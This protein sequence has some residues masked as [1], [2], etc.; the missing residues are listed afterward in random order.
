MAGEATTPRAARRSGLH[1]PASRPGA[2]V[3]A[4]PTPHPPVDR[5]AGAARET[6][7]PAVFLNPK[8]RL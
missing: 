7:A 4:W 5:Q 3:L 1:G 6:G 8:N 2:A